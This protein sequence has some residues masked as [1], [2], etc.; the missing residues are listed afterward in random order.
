ME[1]N[2]ILDVDNDAQMYALHKVYLPRLQVDLGN[3]REVWNNHPIRTAH[4]KTPNQ[5]W[6]AGQ[7]TQPQSYTSIQNFNTTREQRLAQVLSFRQT[8]QLPEPTDIGI[9]LSR[10]PPPLSPDIMLQLDGTI[11][12]GRHSDS[13]AIDIYGEVMTFIMSNRTV[14]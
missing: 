7:I 10:I 2:R 9:V 3:W 14:Q 6:H 8:Y 12:I 4:N 11:D 1:N 5:L 13:N